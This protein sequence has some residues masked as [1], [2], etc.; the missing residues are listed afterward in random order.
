M[1]GAGLLR[2]YSFVQTPATDGRRGGLPL[3]HT[4]TINTFYPE[5]SHSS[6][7]AETRLARLRGPKASV[8]SV[9]RRLVGTRLWCILSV[10]HAPI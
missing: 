7:G 1:S 6:T 9:T 10:C 8:P 2:N 3:I 5:M 4:A